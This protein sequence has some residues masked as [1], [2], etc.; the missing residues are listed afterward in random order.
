VNVFGG[1][2]TELRA[3]SYTDGG[4]FFTGFA[5]SVCERN[6]V[7]SCT[8]V[9]E[10]YRFITATNTITFRLGYDYNGAAGASGTTAA[11]QFG[12]RF[13]CV[14]LPAQGPLPVNVFDFG[15]NH[16]DG[17][18]TLKWSASNEQGFDR[19]E[20]QR[21]V[22][23]TDF[24]RVADV[25]AAGVISSSINYAYADD[26]KSVNGSVVFYRLKLIEADGKFSFSNTVSL[27][28]GSFG[29]K[30]NIS[31]NPASSNVVIRFKADQ[32]G[33]ADLIIADITG[34]VV[35]QR[36]AQFQGGDNNISVPEISTLTDG[37]YTVKIVYGNE[38]VQERLVKRK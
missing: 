28:K 17:V 25:N 1:S 32:S 8:Q 14:N 9:A 33:V 36:K 29:G 5:G 34:R 3:Y 35:L 27:R 24:S 4:N 30:I 13:N 22:N 19:Y 2:P 11:R 21:S 6:N 18:A 15:V 23:G 26:I 7:S 10:F 16:K 20:I 38:T 12:T 31:P 37:V